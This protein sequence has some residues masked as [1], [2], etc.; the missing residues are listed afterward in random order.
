MI[1]VKELSYVRDEATHRWE[2]RVPM[3]HIAAGERV[4]IVGESG[5][6]KSTLLGLMSGWL[7]P[8]SGEIWFDETP[9]HHLKSQARARWRS[10]HL[11]WQGPE[12]ELFN[13]LSALENLDA[14]VWLG[15]SEPPARLYLDQAQEVARL[16]PRAWERTLSHLSQG[17]KQR[18]G[19]ARA[20]AQAY[21]Q[22][23]P[24]L[25]L[26]E[27]T[28]HLNQGLAREI[29]EWITQPRAQT[30]T[31]IATHDLTLAAQCD[32]ILHLKDH[33]SSCRAH[34]IVTIEE[35]SPESE[36]S[37]SSERSQSAQDAMPAWW[38]AHV[39]R[40]RFAL[41]LLW[42]ERWLYTL[43]MSAT[44]LA[45]VIPN[46]T[47]RLVQ[48]AREEL[49][50]RAAS[51][52]LTLGAIGSELDLFFA[53]LYFSASPR[54]HLTMRDA[55]TLSQS[56]PEL[57]TPL[58][59]SGEARGA[60]LVATDMSYAERRH[61]SVTEGRWPTLIGEIALSHTL[62]QEMGVTSLGAELMT[63]I[64]DLYQL[65]APTPIQLKVVGYL[66]TTHEADQRALFTTLPTGWA[67]L[68]LAHDHAPRRGELGAGEVMAQRLTS[69]RY[70]LHKEPEQLPLTA[71][72]LFP[73]DQRAR[74]L[75]RARLEA[76]DTF[77]VIE[78]EQIAE[79]TLQVAEQL[80]RMLSPLL[81]ILAALTGVLIAF[82][83]AQRYVERRPLR[84]TQSALGLTRVEIVGIVAREY[85]IILSLIS[86]ILYMT[87]KLIDHWL[88]PNDLWRILSA[89]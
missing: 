42:D 11:A 12:I 26:D 76:S 75:M 33:S 28:A 32:R 29:T 86:I 14:D 67:A 58:L 59:L 13:A 2:L 54:A 53:S 64:T 24:L 6:G 89:V 3:L 85:V 27:P 40:W 66:K 20:V 17:E 62:A 60:P 25:L 47:E 51:T 55:D 44:L 52:P 88:S 30:A 15:L 84:R 41:R 5:V 73:R 21:A 38:R 37:G 56:A 82:M 4:A 9:L 83:L 71:L 48:G 7:T 70:H 80:N 8:T 22:G 1:R 68:G 77:T 65:T 74:T 78:P 45:L 19:V 36:R 35:R 46:A 87:L 50:A 61:I 31:M 34:R 72:L 69:A 49:S 10:R 57:I 63:D 81:N 23:R 79:D 39:R 43:V 16:A 18:V